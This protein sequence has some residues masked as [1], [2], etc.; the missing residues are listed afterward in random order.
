MHAGTSLPWTSH[1]EDENECSLSGLRMP[2]PLCTK[3]VEPWG[4]SLLHAMQLVMLGAGSFVGDMSLLYPERYAVR[5]ATAIAMGTVTA[6]RCSIR[7]FKSLVQASTLA[8]MKAIAEQKADLTSRRLASGAAKVH[9]CIKLPA[10]QNTRMN[11][12]FHHAGRFQLHARTSGEGCGCSCSKM[13]IAATSQLE[14]VTCAHDPSATHT[15][16]QPAHVKRPGIIT[17]LAS[18]RCDAA[19]QPAEQCQAAWRT[20]IAAGEGA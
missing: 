2:T 9:P 8:R 14:L 17:F 16:M 18:V 11:Q 7:R 10:L 19:G 15:N 13:R 5:S 6:V 4:Q 3:P 1:A 12:T 20:R